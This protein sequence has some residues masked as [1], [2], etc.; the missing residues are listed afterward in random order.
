MAGAPVAGCITQS[1]TLHAAPVIGRKFL[2][3]DRHGKLGMAVFFAQQP[4]THPDVP[5]EPFSP[6]NGFR[7]GAQ[8][9]G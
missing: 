6:G 9:F 3:L 4:G 1:H 5:A 7:H 2:A 8:G